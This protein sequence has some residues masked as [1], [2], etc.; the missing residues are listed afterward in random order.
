MSVVQTYDD[1]VF[2]TLQTT[3]SS[4]DTI[5]TQLTWF[6]ADSA[7]EAKGRISMVGKVLLYGTVLSTGAALLMPRRRR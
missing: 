3:T 1:R 5:A 2:D 7:E 4:L 6:G